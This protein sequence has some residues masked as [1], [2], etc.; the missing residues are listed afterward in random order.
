MKTWAVNR[1]RI[2]YVV[3]NVKMY[4]ITCGIPSIDELYLD[5]KD[6]SSILQG[7]VYDSSALFSR[8][9]CPCVPY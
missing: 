2:H 3:R 5:V 4:S 9:Y 7:M 6:I 8:C 1:F